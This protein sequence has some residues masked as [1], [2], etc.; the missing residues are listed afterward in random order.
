MALFKYF[1]PLI[2]TGELSDP[3]VILS[4]LMYFMMIEKANSCISSRQQIIEIQWVVGNTFHK[5]F[6][7]VATSVSIN[8]NWLTPFVKSL[9]HKNWNYK[10]LCFTL[11]A[12]QS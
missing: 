2:V 12:K 3:K 4:T 5:E 11:F 1:K 6:I 9:G 8:I 10:L 7:T